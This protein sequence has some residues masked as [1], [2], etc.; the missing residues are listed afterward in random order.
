ML[1]KNYSAT[2]KAAKAADGS[3][4][5]EVEAL[6]SVFGNVDLVGDRVVK[7]AFADDLKNWKESGDPIPMVWSHDWGNPLS[8]IGA[9]DTASAEETD[10][11]LL[12]KGT[13]DV[14]VGNPIADQVARL[15][16][17]RRV[18]E[19]SFAYDIQKEAPAKDGANELLAVR[20]I[21]AGP[22]LKGANPETELLMAKAERAAVKAG[23][24][25]SAKNEQAIRS[26]KEALEGVLSSLGDK[27][28][29][30]VKHDEPEEDLEA[31]HGGDPDSATC[32]A[33]GAPT[34]D[35]G[36]YKAPE[37]AEETDE[38]A[39]AE[40]EAYVEK[41]AREERDLKARLDRLVLDI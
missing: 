18:K 2:F 8:H 28:E 14:G 32:K 4:T 33:C 15:L 19:F 37:K 25:L 23:R 40:D 26:A 16:A 9:W 10:D 22:T 29:K 39:V 31:K 7:G 34:D 5:G 12:L 1:V 36:R 30:A 21:E 38:V 27:D 11:G 41:A 17:D 3:P 20:I 24:V 6:V 35:E 13:I